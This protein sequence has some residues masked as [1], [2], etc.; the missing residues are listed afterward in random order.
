[1]N[2]LAC[3]YFHDVYSSSSSNQLPVC[4]LESTQKPQP[5]RRGDIYQDLLGPHVLQASTLHDSV[6]PLQYAGSRLP[7]FDMRHIRRHSLYFSF[8]TGP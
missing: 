5:E 6:F 4:V 2:A 7:S 1:M 3:G 8:P